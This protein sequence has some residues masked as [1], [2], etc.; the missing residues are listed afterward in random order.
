MK[1]IIPT[2]EMEIIQNVAWHENQGVPLCKCYA[3]LPKDDHTKYYR[4]GTYEECL[5]TME[6]LALNDTAILN[7]NYKEI[8]E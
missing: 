4:C 3:L 1:K 2:T 7:G 8:G 5:E 6:Y